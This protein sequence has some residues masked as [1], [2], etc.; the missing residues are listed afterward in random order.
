MPQPT[1]AP[2]TAAPTP[3][4]QMSA[5]V[6]AAQPTVAPE[7]MCEVKEAAQCPGSDTRC[8]GEECCPPVA[9]SG[10]LTFPCPSAPPGWALGRC[11]NV[12]KVLDCTGLRAGGKGGKGGQG[13]GGADSQG[14]GGE[15]A[16]ADGEEDVDAQEESDEGVAAQAA[17]NAIDSHEGLQGKGKGG[18]GKGGADRQEV[19]S[20]IRLM[21]FNVWYGNGHFTEIAELIQDQV[22][23]DIVSLQEAVNTQPAA[24]LE[25]LGQKQAGEWKLANEFN[26][27]TFWCGLNAYRS[28]RWDL[29]WTKNVAYQG[30]RGMCGAR[31]RRKADGRKLCVW[32]THPIWR[33]GGPPSHAVEGVQVAAAAMKECAA[34]GAVS[35][36]LCDCNTFDTGSVK[37]QLAAS[38][39]WAWDVAHADGYDHIYLQTGTGVQGGDGVAADMQGN[40]AAPVS[41]NTIAPGSGAR[42]CQRNCQNPQWAFADHPPVFADVH[43]E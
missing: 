34:A 19:N 38:T 39:G 6:P 41:G 7:A 33:S 2:E 40:L 13:K 25:A 4:P 16:A 32:G 8:Y 43:L 11:Q 17:T 35:A 22:D 18:Q 37:R 3:V 36:L 1:A 14:G 28:D 10:G 15:Q 26:T 31:L 29:E 20:D 42:G 27:T 23:P 30:D 24:I 12:T 9:E 5:P 21:S